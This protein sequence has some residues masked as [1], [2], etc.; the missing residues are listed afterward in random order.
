[1]ELI[2]LNIGS[3]EWEY[4]W[5]WVASHPLNETLE[6]PS[7]AEN[8]ETNQTWQYV[9]TFMQ[10]G[11]AIHEFRHRHHPLTNRREYL[12]LNASENF[13]EDQIAKK[14]KIK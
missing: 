3:P 5:D 11:K 4:A 10:K 7:V 13:N 1:M 14:I 12:Y 2:I 6:N 8:P 9:G